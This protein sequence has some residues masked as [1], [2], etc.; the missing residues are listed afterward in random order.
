MFFRGRCSTSLI[1]SGVRL[2]VGR[3]LEIGRP[4]RDVL[5]RRQRRK[6]RAFQASACRDSLFT[7]IRPRLQGFKDQKNMAIAVP[8]TLCLQHHCRQPTFG[9]TQALRA[10]RMPAKTLTAS[11]QANWIRFAPNS[12]LA[13]SSDARSPSSFLFLVTMPFAPSSFLLGVAPYAFQI[14]CPLPMQKTRF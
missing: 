11:F 12:V 7:V 4:L 5:E 10:S 9:A 2:V 8:S 3:W 14:V 1:V 6:R 13:T